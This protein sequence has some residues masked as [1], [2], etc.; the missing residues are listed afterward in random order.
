MEILIHINIKEEKSPNRLF[1]LFKNVSP[2]FSK[3]VINIFELKKDSSTA[4]NDAI[5][6]LKNYKET[7]RFN[8]CDE[9]YKTQIEAIVTKSQ[10]LTKKR[11]R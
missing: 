10:A 6:L 8:L 1:Q 9:I 4:A 11:M 3:K 5:E 7:N 2:D